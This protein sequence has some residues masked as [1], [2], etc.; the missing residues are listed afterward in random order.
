[1]YT[2]RLTT[3][4]D[5]L[6]TAA[7]GGAFTWTAPSFF[8]ATLQQLH[9]ATPAGSSDPVL[10]IVQL[11]G[12]NDGLNTLVPFADDHYRKARPSL[13][14]GADKVLKFDDAMGFHPSLTG[15]RDLYGEGLL[16]VVQ[17][18]GYPN[19]N[20]SHFRS[21]EIWQT[22]S[23]ANRVERHGWIGRY[24]DNACG[25]CDATAAICLGAE[26]PQAFAAATPRGLVFQDPRQFRRLD[27]P[28]AADPEDALYRRM[29]HL[30]D[31]GLQAGGSIGA[32][33]GSAASDGSAPL[34][35]LAR[36]AFDAEQGSARVRSIAAAAALQ[37]FPATRLGRELELTAR[38][39][40]GGLPSR[41]YYLS[42]GGFDTHS[43]QPGT[44]DRLLRELGDALLAFSRE[45]KRQG[46]HQRVAVMV[47]S[48]FGRRV[49]ENASRG[50]DHG[51][52]AP[53]FLLGG[54]LSPGLHGRAPSLAPADLDHGD[55]KHATDFRSVYATLLERHLRV[56][57]APILGRAYPLLGA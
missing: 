4:R 2:P 28:D 31:E 20:R 24:F 13:A 33:G 45:M 40:G 30:D 12:G 48:E 26:A 1:M 3:R 56:K 9:A 14:V 10:V 39:I 34:D 51:A 53:V 27:T 17:A 18:V 38:F 41:I 42:H 25:G 54:G 11:A 43:N 16:S 7:L 36:V 22:A 46:E 29:N 15:L 44:H 21:M 19:P 32:L 8:A 55:V 37:G 6:R 49:A 47:F 50:T 57:S 5:F 35:F 23:D 52:A